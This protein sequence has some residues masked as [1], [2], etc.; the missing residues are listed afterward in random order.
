MVYT[1]SGDST[2]DKLIN[3]YWLYYC[4][5]SVLAT[6]TVLS[7]IA[8]N[9]QAHSFTS[10]ILVACPANSNDMKS[11]STPSKFLNNSLNYKQAVRIWIALAISEA[12]CASRR[13]VEGSRTSASAILT[14]HRLYSVPSLS[15]RRAVVLGSDNVIL[16]PL[17]DITPSLL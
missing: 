17:V 7:Q 4:M 9:A 12:I 1:T 15:T 6:S 14:R 10:N 16:L 3:S 11:I 2:A 13:L 8:V 5:Y